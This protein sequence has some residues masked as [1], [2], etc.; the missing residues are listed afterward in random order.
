MSEP[1][2]SGPKAVCIARG[3][4]VLPRAVPYMRVLRRGHNPPLAIV[5]LVFS[6]LVGFL[7]CIWLQNLP[8]LY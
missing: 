7:G 5:A 3:M 4:F 2:P 8:A 6:C 1:Q